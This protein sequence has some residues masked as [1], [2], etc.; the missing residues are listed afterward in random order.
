MPGSHQILPI[1]QGTTSTRAI[2]F[3]EFGHP[4]QTSQRELRQIFPRTGW[5]EHDPE[6]IW[7]ATLSVCREVLESSHDIAALGLAN[8]RET[9]LLWERDTG[10]PLHNA[11]VWQDR[12][13]AQACRDI[14]AAGHTELIAAQTGLLPNA[15]FSASKLAWL[16]DH[17]D[18]ARARA[19]AGELAF[20]TVD[21]FLLMISSIT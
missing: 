1:D 3:D 2:L 21:S 18:G 19:E 11:I 5:V 17:V 13:T 7:S 6:E 12:R 4:I 16:L 20:G 14:A 8:Q 9:T 10:M 15:Y